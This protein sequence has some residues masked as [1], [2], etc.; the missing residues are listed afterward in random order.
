MMDIYVVDYGNVNNS[1]FISHFR[2]AMQNMKNNNM[3]P[4][5]NPIISPTKF[6][7]LFIEDKRELND[8][9]LALFLEELKSLPETGTAYHIALERFNNNAQPLDE[10][11]PLPPPPRELPPIKKKG[12]RGGKSKK[13][14][15][16]HNKKTKKL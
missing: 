1:S 12:S 6:I 9:F 16:K 15:M 4:Y 2:T 10:F 11:Q 7:Q 13:H 5:G 8:R 3:V 14:R